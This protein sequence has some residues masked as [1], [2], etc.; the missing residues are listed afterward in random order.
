MGPH[1]FFGSNFSLCWSNLVKSGI[2][3]HISCYMMRICH[4]QSFGVIG[5]FF[6]GA[7]LIFLIKFFTF[8]VK[9]GIATHISCNM[10]RIG[11]GQSFGVIEPFC[12]FSSSSTH[13]SDQFFHFLI[14]FGWILDEGNILSSRYLMYVVQF[15]IWLLKIIKSVQKWGLYYEVNGGIVA[16]LSGG[17]ILIKIPS[18][19]GA[20]YDLTSNEV[21]MTQN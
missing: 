20:M 9:S 11:H 13:F 17:P 14:K 8:L 15:M 3:T 7:P 12:I 6:Y 18:I 5:P 16:K 4:G 10:M 1:T 19:C 2:A 21:L